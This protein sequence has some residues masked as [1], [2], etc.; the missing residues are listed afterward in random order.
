MA[1]QDRVKLAIAGLGTVGAGTIA[2]IEAQG[3]L[4]ADR[5]GRGV[6]VTAVSARDRSRDRGV[7]LSP[8]AWWDDPVAMAREADCD[9]V[10]ELIGGSDGVAKAV[11]EAAIGAGRHVVTANKALIAHHG[12]ALARAA[13]AGG[14]SL[15]F[16]AAV[17]GGIPII[18]AIR[19]GL[20]GNRIERVHGILNGTC[21]YILTEMRETGRPFAE[22]LEEAQ[23]LGYAEADPSFDVDG[24][25]AAHK[26]AILASL[27]FGTEVDFTSVH[28]EGI[29]RIAP[30]DIDFADE[31]GFKIKLLGIAEKTAEGISQRVHPT[32]VPVDAPIA[33]VEGVTNAVETVGDFV[34]A[35]VLQ[36]AGAGAGPTASAVIADVLDVAAGRRAPVFGVPADRLSAPAP[37]PMARHEGAYYVRLRVIDRPGVIADVTAVLRDHKV[38]MES[39]IQRGRD[40][41]EP[42]DVVMTTHDTSE[43]AMQHVLAGIDG[44]DAVV[45]PPTVIRIDRS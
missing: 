23:K 33:A 27:A 1:G 19:E 3:D 16:E 43:A 31:L 37:L 34:G 13:E 6:A 12:A 9:V 11:C 29:R 18:K 7:D 45:E 24:V 44:L 2:L 15:G 5:A 4:L 20:A 22:V 41:E 14:V 21:N 25:D 30:L 36:G 35:T 40:P 28:I 38:S 10:V 42:V 32:M 39:I 26:L 8:F 17:A